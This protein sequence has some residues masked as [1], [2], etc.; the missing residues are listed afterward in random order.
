MIRVSLCH[1]LNLLYLEYLGRF[2]R[3]RFTMVHYR[4]ASLVA[5]R[6]VP[7]G[8]QALHAG[9]LLTLY[10]PGVPFSICFKINITFYWNSAARDSTRAVSCPHMRPWRWR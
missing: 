7:Q 1:V 3:D 10:Y 5:W 4:R 8:W 6:A 2:R 9:R